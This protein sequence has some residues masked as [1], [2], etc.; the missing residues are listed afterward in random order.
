VRHQRAAVVTGN[1]KAAM[2][3]RRHHPDLIERQRAFR[4][5]D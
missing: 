2:A 3:E 1:R 5:V 4:I